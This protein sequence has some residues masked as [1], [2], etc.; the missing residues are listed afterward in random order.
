MSTEE[1]LNKFIESES[2]KDTRIKDTFKSLS[3][4]NK[5]KMD[6]DVHYD[7]FK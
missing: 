6:N 5:K 7:H 1:L 2:E 4:S 3:L